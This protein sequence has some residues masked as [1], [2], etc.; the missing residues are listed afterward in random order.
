MI[1]VYRLDDSIEYVTDET[2]TSR[3]R[4]AESLRGAIAD[5]LNE[6]QTE[7][8]LFCS[9][10]G[11]TVETAFEDM[12]SVKRM[13][14]KEDGV[15]GYHLV[16][17][18]A[19]GEVTPELA[20]QVGLELAEK[21]L[22]G[23]FQVIVSTHLNTGHIHN[24]LL[25]NSVSV[26][27][28]AKYHSNRKT[29]LRQIRTFSD[30]LCRKY[31]LSV[32]ETE[33][34]ERSSLPYVQWLAEKNGKPTWK[35]PYQQDIAEAVAASLTWRQFLAA[36]ERA[37]PGV[38]L[39]DI[40]L[41]DGDGLEVLKH[42]KTR[43]PDVSV[44]MLSALSKET[45]KVKGLNLGADDYIAKPFGVLELTAR[46]NAALRRSGKTPILRAGHLEMNTENMRVTFRG[47]ELP[48]N[49]KEFQLLRYCILN[50]GKVMTRESLLMDVWGYD[51]G[52]TRTLDNHIARLRKFGLNFETVFGVGYKFLA[53]ED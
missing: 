31:G 47:K 29:Y 42:V 8:D 38:V 49:N 15:Q 44:I 25:W 33:L 37:L 50:E 26:E 17:S 35:T 30:E 1:P 27:D 24:H 21:V 51:Y 45:D 52:E 36:M 41:S 6:K 9:A 12:C 39:L 46:V 19:A 22:G 32:I 34:S 23:R 14:H 43:W 5:A 2:K 18:F 28:G 16:Q 10:L 4:H 53:D 20:H 48:L 3:S 11:C 13:W 40:M 7:R